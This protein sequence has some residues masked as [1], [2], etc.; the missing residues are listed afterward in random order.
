VFV[1]SK[2][3]LGSGTGYDLV[4]RGVTGTASDTANWWHDLDPTRHL[5]A[6]PRAP[7]GV[8]AAAG[9]VSP[10]STPASCSAERPHQPAAGR[11]TVVPDRRW[12]RLLGLRPIQDAAAGAAG[13]PPR[14]TAPKVLP[15]RTWTGPIRA[16]TAT[17][18][19]VTSTTPPKW[20]ATKTRAS[21]QQT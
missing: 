4:R 20:P 9:W 8:L 11:P 10:A 18:W 16:I 13:P 5:G 2:E 15:P 6:P 12:M 17:T 21:P 7:G 19:S 1:I 3:L 14:R